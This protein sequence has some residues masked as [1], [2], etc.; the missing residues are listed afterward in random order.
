MSVYRLTMYGLSI[1][2]TGCLGQNSGNTGQLELASVRVQSRIEKFDLPT[3]AISI[4]E[5]DTMYTETY[6][7]MKL[8]AFSREMEFHEGFSYSATVINSY[9]QSQSFS[10]DMVVAYTFANGRLERA[11]LIPLHIQDQFLGVFKCYTPDY[12]SDYRRSRAYT[13]LTDTLGYKVIHEVI[14]L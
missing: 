12:W 1:L 3:I 5:K 14:Q 6:Y 4:I 9:T 11:A 2:L 10:N 13:S 7:K 8:E